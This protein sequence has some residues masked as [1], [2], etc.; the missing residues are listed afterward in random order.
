VRNVAS[1]G[2]RGGSVGK[3]GQTSSGSPA[4]SGY[5]WGLVEL[6]VEEVELIVD[7]SLWCLCLVLV[8]VVP[9]VVVWVES[10]ANAVEPITSAKPNTKLETVFMIMSPCCHTGCDITSALDAFVRLVVTE[11]GRV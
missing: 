5:F 2:M 4:A 7:L 9:L 3:S 11:A 10:C 8:C 6:L 1:G